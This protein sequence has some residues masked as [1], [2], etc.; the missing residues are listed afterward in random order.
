MA[1]ILASLRNF[2]EERAKGRCEY[3]LCQA[4][5]SP[6]SFPIDHIIPVSLNG[7]TEE[8]NLAYSCGG[9]NGHKHK[10]INAIDPLTNKLAPLFH[11]RQQEWEDHFQW[12]EDALHILG[13]S[14]TGR[15]T[16]VLL[17]LNRASNLNLRQLLKSVGLHPL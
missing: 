7:K 4:A 17:Q 5:L 16:E 14:A 12:S 11:P 10:R 8:Q 13:I 6:D 2:V 3:C 15:A 9:C 1:K